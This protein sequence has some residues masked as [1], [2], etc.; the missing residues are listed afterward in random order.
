[1][2]TETAVKLE[3]VIDNGYVEI[4][5]I[6]VKSAG[7]CNEALKIG[8]HVRVLVKGY[9]DY[10]AHSGVITH[11]DKFSTLPT[12]TVCYVKTCHSETKLVFKSVNNETKDVEIVKPEELEVENLG[13]VRGRAIQNLE[14]NIAKKRKELD[15]EEY[16]LNW[17][18]QYYGKYF[19][20]V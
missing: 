18:I 14:N 15:D 4:K 3:G 1:M 19:G 2:S 7:G 9:S 8:D 13:G 5:G 20:D 16:K 12:V 6:K 17:F 11:F 10:S